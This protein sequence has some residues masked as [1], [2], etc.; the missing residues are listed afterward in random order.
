MSCR[1]DNTAVNRQVCGNSS[2]ETRLGFFH[3]AT[4][5]DTDGL[6]VRPGGQ[7]EPDLEEGLLGPEE[8]LS[9]K[10]LLEEELCSLL[11]PHTGRDA[12]GPSLCCLCVHRL[13]V[14]QAAEFCCSPLRRGG[15]PTAESGCLSVC[16]LYVVVRLG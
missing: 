12:L 6:G 14:H 7:A 11:D 9:V 8:D 10:R 13:P 15:W 2:L 16:L 1:D 3:R 4:I 5:P